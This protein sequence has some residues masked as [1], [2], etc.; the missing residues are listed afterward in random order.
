MIDLYDLAAGKLAALFVR[1]TARDLFDS[2]L[3]FSIE[4]LEIEKLRV[5][6]VV[7]G[8]MNRR[9]GLALRFH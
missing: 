8:A 9:D 1:R 7:Y 6:F 4:G 2:S 5:A 3:I